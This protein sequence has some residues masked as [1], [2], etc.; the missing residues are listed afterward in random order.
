MTNVTLRFINHRI[1]PHRFRGNC[2]S[3]GHFRA[4]E[5]YVGVASGHPSG[6]TSITFR[7]Q[8]WTATGHL[9]GSLWSCFGTTFGLLLG[10]HSVTFG[11]QSWNISGTLLVSFLDHF[12]SLSEL[13][14]TPFWT[15][16]GQLSGLLLN[17]FREPGLGTYATSWPTAV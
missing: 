17:T 16:F 14:C 12:W 4:P 10:P 1:P 13:F 9:S 2:A 5:G 6:L 11:C 15:N 3:R 7:D 8:C